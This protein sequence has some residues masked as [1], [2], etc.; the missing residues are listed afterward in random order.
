MG[1][2]DRPWAKPDDPQLLE[3]PKIKAVAAKYNKTA[4]QVV[5][6][7]QVQ[8]GCITIPKSVNKNRIKENFNIWDFNLTSE[9][10]ALLDTF[11]VNGRICPY[12]E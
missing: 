7:Y 9:D 1:S 3:D 4:A 12:T 8:R 5:L 6:K 2:P 10:I 11:D